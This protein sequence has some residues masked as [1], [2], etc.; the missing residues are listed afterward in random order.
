[1]S[2]WDFFVFKVFSVFPFRPV[3]K[4]FGLMV[5]LVFIA[6]IRKVFVFLVDI[7]FEWLT[8]SIEVQIENNRQT[9]KH[10]YDK[11]ANTENFKFWIDSCYCIRF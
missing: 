9:R 11:N 3:L 5:L 7:S 8:L 1:M 6:S 4:V 10:F 2:I